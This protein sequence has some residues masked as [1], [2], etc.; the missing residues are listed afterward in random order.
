MFLPETIFVLIIM[1][2]ISLLVLIII[3]VISLLFCFYIRKEKKRS[4]YIYKHINNQDKHINNQD[5]KIT[6]LQDQM[7]DMKELLKF[8]HN[9]FLEYENV[10]DEKFNENEERSKYRTYYLLLLFSSR[11]KTYVAFVRIVLFRKKA[12]CLIM[13]IIENN[14]ESLRKTNS[15]FYDI[16]KPDDNQKQ[17]AFFIIYSSESKIKD[18][19]KYLVNII[20][21]FL[22]FIHDYASTKIHLNKLEN[23]NVMRNININIEEQLSSS[24]ENSGK[25][26]DATT[27]KS[28][29]LSEYLLNSYDIEK[30]TRSIINLIEKEENI[31]EDKKE[32][33]KKK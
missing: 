2:V 21:D 9:F 25:K 3:C 7:Q 1:N 13:A 24:N 19:E 16:L 11:I 15:K 20:I 33:D 6:D 14:S 30:E 22:M 31:I 8:Q 18:V 27:F 5:K 29:E 17:K 12:N 32:E 23:F 4:F 26:T 28:S 10:K